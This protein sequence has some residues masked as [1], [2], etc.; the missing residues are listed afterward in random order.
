MKNNI[1]II[2]IISATILS[3]IVGGNIGV[4]SFKNWHQ[5]YTIR[6]INEYFK[7]VH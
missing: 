5:E 1:I 3:I 4:Q 7:D 2:I 6:Q